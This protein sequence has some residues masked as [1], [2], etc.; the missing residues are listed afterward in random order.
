M[1]NK[2]H[3]ALNDE[4]LTSSLNT[5]LYVLL[6]CMFSGLSFISLSSMILSY[7]HWKICFSTLFRPDSFLSYFSV[8]HRSRKLVDLTWCGYQNKTLSMKFSVLMNIFQTEILHANVSLS[9][10]WVHFIFPCFFVFNPLKPF[11]HLGHFR[12]TLNFSIKNC[13][14]FVCFICCIF[15][16]LPIKTDFLREYFTSKLFYH[17]TPVTEFAALTCQILVHRHRRRWGYTYIMS[18]LGLHSVHVLTLYTDKPHRFCFA[19]EGRCGTCNQ[20]IFYI[21]M[22]LIVFFFLSLLWLP[23]D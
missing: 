5:V 22:K 12:F 1:G 9:T 17:G 18:F 21:I 3:K 2:R 6:G 14:V 11:R 8:N 15:V 23:M 19:W 10:H 4:K 13:V 20:M 16:L 7:C